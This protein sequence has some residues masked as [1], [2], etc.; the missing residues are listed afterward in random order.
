MGVELDGCCC[1][2]GVV[3][4]RPVRNRLCCFYGCP[5]HTNRQLHGAYWL[6]V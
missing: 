3:M 5:V 4:H 1:R 6:F 2:W